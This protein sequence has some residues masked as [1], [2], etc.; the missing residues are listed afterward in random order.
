MSSQLYVYFKHDLGQKYYAP[1]VRPNRGSNSRPPD[2][3]RTLQVTETPSVTTSCS[4][5]PS[6]ALNDEV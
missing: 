3:D 1:Q 4:D 6:Q 5:F 2:H